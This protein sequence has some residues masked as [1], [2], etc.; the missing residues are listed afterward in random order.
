MTSKPAP[1][2]IQSSFHCI[3]HIIN[4]KL[5]YLSLRLTAIETETAKKV[6]VPRPKT[7]TADETDVAKTPAFS[8]EV[9]DISV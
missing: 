3:F 5:L 7:D 6:I 2:L 4:E 1:L 9:G 8:L